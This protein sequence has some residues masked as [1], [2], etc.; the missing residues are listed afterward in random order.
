[1]KNRLHKVC[2]G[3]R[4]FLIGANT[5]LWLIVFAFCAGFVIVFPLW[6]LAV[7]YTKVYT[8]VSIT[9][10]SLLLLFW[11]V[12]ICI[13]KYKQ[14]PRAFF[15]GLIKKTILIIG[16]VAFLFFLFQYQRIVAF[17]ALAVSIIVDVFLSFGFLEDKE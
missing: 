2:K 7:S 16:I 10:F 17:S 14:N 1:M 6:K 4:S 5:F 11:F 15:Y 8:I 13:K 9:F 3:C 12:R